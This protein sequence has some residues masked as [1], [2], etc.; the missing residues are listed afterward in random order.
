[1]LS[2][3]NY[4]LKVDQKLE[5]AKTYQDEVDAILHLIYP[6]VPEIKLTGARIWPPPHESA[7]DVTVMLCNH[8][9]DSD[10]AIVYANLSWN[11]ESKFPTKF[12]GFTYSSFEYL[13]LVGRLVG[14]TLVALEPGESDSDIEHKISWMLAQGYNTWLLFPEG[15]LMNKQSYKKSL[16]YQK[17]LGIPEEKWLHYVLYPKVRALNALLRVV[18]NRLKHIVDITIQYEDFDPRYKESSYRFI[19]YP[20][21]FTGYLAQQ[22]SA[23]MHVHIYDVG[24]NWRPKLLEHAQHATDNKDAKDKLAPPWLINL[25]NI[26]DKTLKRK[27]KMRQFIKKVPTCPHALD[28]SRQATPIKSARLDPKRDPKGDLGKDQKLDLSQERIQTGSRKKSERKSKLRSPKGIQ[29]GSRKK[30]EARSQKIPKK[31]N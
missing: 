20:S 13:P 23:S 10:Q 21:I 2:L 24:D 12:T 22:K 25:W 31:N 1:M 15:T 19:T 9:S 28:S 30:S 16:D 26:K 18:G 17:S 14:R 4:L 8:A 29:T 7:E 11:K 3:A 6:C 5:N 27:M